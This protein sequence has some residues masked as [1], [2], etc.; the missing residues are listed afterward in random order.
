MTT[1]TEGNFQ[2]KRRS[3]SRPVWPGNP[4]SSSAR[5]GGLWWARRWKADSISVAGRPST[6]PK[7]LRSTGGMSSWIS[8]WSSMTRI[9]TGLF[10]PLGGA[11]PRRFKE[12]DACSHRHVQALHLAE[13]RD[14]HQQIA[15]LAGE[16]AHALALGA[17]HPGD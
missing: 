10:S 17:E 6:S 13:H 5:S 15:A 9:S 1:R 12:D 16:P 2:R 8:A 14:A 3:V 4:R 7:A 11:T